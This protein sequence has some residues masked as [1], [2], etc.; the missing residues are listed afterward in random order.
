MNKNVFIIS[1]TI[2][3]KEILTIFFIILTIEIK[4]LFFYVRKLK[5]LF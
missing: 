5:N 2:K 4:E 3:N 1:E